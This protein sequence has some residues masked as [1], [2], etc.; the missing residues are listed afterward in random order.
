MSATA[1]HLRPWWQV[2]HITKALPKH[3]QI[4]RSLEEDDQKTKYLPE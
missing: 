1:L 4:S 3:C 2:Y